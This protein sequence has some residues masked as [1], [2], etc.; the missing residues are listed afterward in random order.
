[1]IFV[2][3]TEYPFVYSSY[4]SGILMIFLTSTFVRVCSLACVCVFFTKVPPSRN[5]LFGKKV[6]NIDYFQSIV[7]LFSL[8]LV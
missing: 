7:L 6:S 5:S 3:S 8:F 1:M 4:G 2:K